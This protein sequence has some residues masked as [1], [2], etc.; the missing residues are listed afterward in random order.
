MDIYLPDIRTAIEYNGD[1]WHCNP[2]LYDSVY[3]NKNK[4][5]FAYEIWERDRIKQKLCE[6]QNIDLLIVWEQDYK[7]NEQLELNRVKEFIRGH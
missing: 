7:D 2:S 1:Y 6:D 4:Q 5:Q 3:F